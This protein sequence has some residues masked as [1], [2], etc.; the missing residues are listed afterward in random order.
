MD[1]ALRSRGSIV[2]PLVLVFFL[3][4]M[5]LHSIPTAGNDLVFVAVLASAGLALGL[6]SGFAT[7]VRAGAD[8]LALAPVG[9]TAS[10]LL[11]LGIGSRMAF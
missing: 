9:W 10:P 7:R 1:R 2:A 8:G 3:A 5:Y 4:Q 11:I 6:L